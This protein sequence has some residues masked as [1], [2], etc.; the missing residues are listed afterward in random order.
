M[1]YK[2]LAV[3]LDGTLLDD[4]E[5]I[6]KQNLAAIH[7]A[8]ARQVRIVITTGRSYASAENYIRALNVRDACITYNGALIHYG[9][10]VLKKVTMN[11]ETARAAARFLV[12][13][14]FCPIV[15]CTDGRKYY[16]TADSRTR[17]F[18]ESVTGSEKGLTF[19]T[20]L[21]E[22]P[23]R[24]P[25]WSDVIR[26][27]VIVGGEDIAP[28]HASCGKTFGPGIRTIS[29]FFPGW[30]FW[31]FELLDRESSKSTALAF[32]CRLYGIR[33]EEVIAVGD[34]DNDVDMIAWAGKGVAMRN[35]LPS[36]LK[37]ADYITGHSNNEHGV[38]EVIDRFILDGKRLGR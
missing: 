5:T 22:R 10:A 16:E 36:V 12:H 21:L 14:G 28:L 20:G 33:P 6:S 32:V 27:S 2:L 26:V 19:M 29:T 3:D 8:Q 37:A 25:P 38:A 34:N 1:K 35:A 15:Y 30:N 17:D 18:F 23:L 9:S 24:T 4:L 11:D 7:K 31:T 13:S